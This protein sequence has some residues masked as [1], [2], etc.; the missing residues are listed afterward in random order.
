MCYDLAACS[1]SVIYRLRISNIFTSI[2]QMLPMQDQLLLI[3]NDR[4]LSIS[5]TDYS[6][7]VFQEKVGTS[8]GKPIYV[9]LSETVIEICSKNIRVIEIQAKD[10][11]KLSTK[12]TTYTPDHLDDR[13]SIT[14]AIGGRLPRTK[15]LC[16]IM[17][18]H[19]DTDAWETKEAEQNGLLDLER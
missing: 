13:F 2:K 18:P 15:P 10:Q 3:T 11:N 17:C 1:F 16:H 4:I 6:E 12:S 19:C 7:N 9:H 5:G 8:I 14:H